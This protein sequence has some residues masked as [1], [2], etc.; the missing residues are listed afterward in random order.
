MLF[1]STSRSARVLQD[2]PFAERNQS[3][4]HGKADVDVER[5]TGKLDH[6]VL[7]DRLKFP[8]AIDR[9]ADR[10]DDA[11]TDRSCELLAN[12][13]QTDGH[14]KVIR[15]RR[16]F[17]QSAALSAGFHEAKGAVVIAMDGDTHEI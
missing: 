3:S 17:G 10:Q 15:L 13:V 14:L 2:P 4:E 11:S 7:R 6:R 16:N 1:R 8:H 12:L 5:R 9:D